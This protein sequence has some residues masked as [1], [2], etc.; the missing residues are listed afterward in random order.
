MG[1]KNEENSRLQTE[2]LVTNALRE[3][4]SMLNDGSQVSYDEAISFAKQSFPDLFDSPDSIIGKKR[5]ADREYEKYKQ[6]AE[7]SSRVSRRKITPEDLIRERIE[8]IN[9]LIKNPVNKRA[10]INILNAE[11]KRLL[12][13]LAKSSSYLTENQ[14]LLNDYDA[15]RI[16]Y[17][18]IN[19]INGQYKIYN[20]KAGDPFVI[21]FLH[22]GAPET[23]TGVDLIYEYHK[24]GKVR[25]VAV[26]YKIW[27]DNTLYFSKANNI[28]RQLDTAKSCFCGKGYCQAK[29]TANRFRFPYC[30]PFLRPT[31]K[32]K[33]K[34][35]YFSSGWHIPVCQ[36][37]NHTEMGYKDKILRLSGI[38]HVA[39]N[40]AEFE[41]L[42]SR[43]MIGSDWLSINEIEN[44]YKQNKVLEP[45]D[46]SIFIL[47]QRF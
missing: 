4:L 42:F 13:F 31:D 36:I 5:P 37:Q 6:E 38:K 34:N 16:K 1:K 25:I 45:T 30:I 14:A 32:L 26:Q 43:E 40:T 9:E 23:A 19:Q 7:L 22:P 35:S 20:T 3:N 10:E 17:D 41:R 27:E 18:Y 24:D 12:R 8:K 29:K 44:F 39:L 47:S 21:R 11:K 46:N 2:W 28:E 15:Y 33:R